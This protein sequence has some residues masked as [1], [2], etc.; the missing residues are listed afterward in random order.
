MKPAEGDVPDHERTS[1]GTNGR[2]KI[3]GE[4]EVN[5]SLAG[6]ATRADC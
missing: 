2:T 3:K 6:F 5:Q 1:Y 4:T